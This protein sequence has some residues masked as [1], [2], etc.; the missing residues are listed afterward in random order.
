MSD[1]YGFPESRFATHK[2][3]L[4]KLDMKLRFQGSLTDHYYVNKT[5]NKNI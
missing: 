5:E 1:P 3:T 2:E 4:W